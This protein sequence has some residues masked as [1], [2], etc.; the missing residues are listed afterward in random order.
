MQDM[1]ETL[2]KMEGSKVFV[3]LSFIRWRNE[4]NMRVLTWK[5]T[6]L[7]IDPYYLLYNTTSR[8]EL[9]NQKSYQESTCHKMVRAQ[10]KFETVARVT[11]FLLPVKILKIVR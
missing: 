1:G 5:T 9:I 8:S 3:C 2:L 11:S 10:N 4:R 7:H 6:D